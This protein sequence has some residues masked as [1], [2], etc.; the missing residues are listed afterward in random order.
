MSFEKSGNR[1]PGEAPG[2][3]SSLL[4][5]RC[6]GVSAW[7]LWVLLAGVYFEGRKRR[8]RKSELNLVNELAQGSRWRPRAA[9]TRL[10]S[11]RGRN[12]V[13]LKIEEKGRGRSEVL[14]QVWQLSLSLRLL[15]ETAG[16]FCRCLF[17]K[18][19]WS[20]GFE[21]SPTLD[22]GMRKG[23]AHSPCLHESPFGRTD[24][25]M[26]NHQNIHLI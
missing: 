11:L 5:A 17:N 23:T 20:T 1:F 13:F 18:N 14:W 16:S 2:S 12:K 10:A 21:P 3:H 24:M 26:S 7:V 8:E 4:S 15:T 25:H 6:A 9:T 22:P 19:F